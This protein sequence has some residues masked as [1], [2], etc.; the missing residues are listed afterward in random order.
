MAEKF[1][2]TLEQITA[3]TAEILAW[4]EDFDRRVGL[5]KCAASELDKQVAVAVMIARLFNL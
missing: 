1:Q 2:I 5:K 4:I 3:K